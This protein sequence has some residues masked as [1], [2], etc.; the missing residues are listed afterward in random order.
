MQVIWPKISFNPIVVDSSTLQTANN[1]NLHFKL[2]GIHTL[3]IRRQCTLA[4]RRTKF[5]R[6]SLFWPI[7][8]NR[9]PSYRIATLLHPCQRRRHGFSVGVTFYPCNYFI[10]LEVFKACYFPVARKI[11]QVVSPTIR[12]WKGRFQW[13]DIDAWIQLLKLKH[14][15]PGGFQ[16]WTSVKILDPRVKSG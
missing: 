5:F 12:S 11:E 14:I 6:K 9:E 16:P 4:S 13:D 8:L 15:D 7:L 3:L 10:V 1:H 2:L